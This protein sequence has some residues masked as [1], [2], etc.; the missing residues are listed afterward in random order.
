MK[1]LISFDISNGRRRNK[2]AKVLL[3]IGF[4]VQKSV[5]EVFL[6]TD[7]LNDYED[8][9]LQA[10]NPDT[11]SIRIYPLNKTC[12]DAILIIGRGKRIDQ[13]NCLVL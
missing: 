11:D 1:Y 5:F 7:K 9:L 3:G 2:V 13:P 12:D 4:R 8:T 10:I 6:D